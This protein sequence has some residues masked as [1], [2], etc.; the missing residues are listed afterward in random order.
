[1]GWNAGGFGRMSFPTTEAVREWR[2]AQ[3]TYADWDD[4]FAELKPDDDDEFSISELLERFASRHDPVNHGIYLIDFR[5][6]DVELVFEVGE[7]D[8]R[9]NVASLAA[10]LR[11]A[12]VHGA[13]GTFWFLGT[14]GAEYDFV[15]ELN[16][17][18]G[19]SAVKDLS[20]RQLA[21][22]YEGP[23]YRAFHERVTA[24]L[25]AA[26]PGFRKLMTELREGRPA[27]KPSHALHEQVMTALAAYPDKSTAASAAKFPEFI[28]DGQGLA[29]PKKYFAKGAR[30]KFAD[31]T[32]E[33]LYGVA[34]WTL[35]E[36]DPEAAAPIALAALAAAATPTAVKSAAMSALAHR[37][38]T[39]TVEVMLLAIDGDDIMLRY[40]ALRA[41]RV[42]PEQYR[43]QLEPLVTA[44]LQALTAATNPPK[45]NLPGGPSI[46]DVVKSHDLR[47]TVAAVAAFTTSK[48][49]ADARDAA[50]ELI[51]SWNDRDGLAT[52][53]KSI[54]EEFGVGV[55]AA[56]ALIVLDPDAALAE[57]TE[58]A[59]STSGGRQVA[60]IRLRHLLLALTADA[61][62]ARK[63]SVV[64]RD[65]RWIEAA[66]PLLDLGD[67][68][69]AHTLLNLLACSPR[70]PAVIQRLEAVLLAGSIPPIPVAG[71]LRA[72]RS[73]T[74]KAV[75]KERLT[76]TTDQREVEQLR[77]CL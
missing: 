34:L 68:D 18:Q 72:L 8:F 62:A 53:A 7:D 64:H 61:H 43:P 19:R 39:P 71:A 75:I 26:D 9:D 77:L 6:L 35:G 11:S 12:D 49:P 58:T 73:K 31:A 23:G 56:K 50:A 59:G 48:Q 21:K 67:N 28:P 27:G 40:G 38:T 65:P 1:M 5:D 3:R 74:Y 76:I 37:P 57:L 29:D 33:Q 17:A 4:W 63:E 47:G 24:L 2:A 25:E 10:L 51:I 46:V 32:S 41:L 13:T 22:I 70:N 66:L 14:A 16:L 45:V 55:T 36:L 20:S 69:L 42:L 30:D 44:R 15:Y 52:V 54:G 60:D